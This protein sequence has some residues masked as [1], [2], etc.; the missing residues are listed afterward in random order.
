MINNT[1]SQILKKELRGE[2]YTWK[3]MLW[4]VIVSLLFSFT[5]YLLLTNKELSLLDQTELMLLL[6][7]I[8]IMH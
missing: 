6:S 7:K 8:I 2:L 5:C 1:I 4:L 3:S